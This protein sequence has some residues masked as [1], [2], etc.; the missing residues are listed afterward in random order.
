MS[1]R[2]KSNSIVSSSIHSHLSHFSHI[3]WLS[4]NHAS[5]LSDCDI[6]TQNMICERFFI[7]N[8]LKKRLKISDDVICFFLYKKK[9]SFIRVSCTRKQHLTVIEGYI[10]RDNVIVEDDVI[11]KVEINSH[12]LSSRSRDAIRLDSTR[13][14]FIQFLERLET[15]WW[16]V[17]Y[18]YRCRNNSYLSTVWAG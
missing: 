16:Y 1:G 4:R 14:V 7:F 3:T 13:Y 15:C 9:F 11:I 6:L 10:E 5:V 18:Y 2:A 17:C 12:S 8:S